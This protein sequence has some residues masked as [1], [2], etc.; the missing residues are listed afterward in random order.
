MDNVISVFNLFESS[1]KR[2]INFECFLKFHKVDLDLP[3]TKRKE[4]IGLAKTRRVE[5]YKAYDTYHLLYKET[6]LTFESIK[7]KFI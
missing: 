5:R 3:E 2:K 1:P 6:V 7:N 4:F